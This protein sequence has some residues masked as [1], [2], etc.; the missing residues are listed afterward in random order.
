MFILGMACV[1]IGIS[2]LAPDDSKGN[3]NILFDG[4][5]MIQGMQSINFF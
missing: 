4:F 1:F 5:T 3:Y 2:L